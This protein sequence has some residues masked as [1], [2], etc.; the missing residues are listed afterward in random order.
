MVFHWEHCEPPNQLA[1]SQIHM[2]A[3]GLGC[4]GETLRWGQAVGM[5]G[6]SGVILHHPVLLLVL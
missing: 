1:G 2:W 5:E 3:R 6:G 4:A